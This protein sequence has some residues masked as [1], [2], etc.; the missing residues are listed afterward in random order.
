MGRGASRL[1]YEVPTD[2]DGAVGLYDPFWRV[3]EG[4]GGA[5]GALRG[6]SLG[7]RDGTLILRL[8]PRPGRAW[9]VPAAD[10]AGVRTG[11]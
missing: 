7:I 6:S 10:Y 5:E 3:R 9:T 2:F 1:E 11:P 8:E 4:G